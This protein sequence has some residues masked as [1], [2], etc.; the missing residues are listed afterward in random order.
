MPDPTAE[1]PTSAFT[2]A[3]VIPA[4]CLALCLALV[5]GLA[6]L[7][8]R[9]ALAEAGGAEDL[10][11]RPWAEIEARARGGEVNFFMWGGSDSINAY[12]SDYIGGLMKAR[13]DITLNRVPLTETADAVAIVLA[14]K[15]AG[16]VADGSV[17]LIWING[18]NFRTMRQGG[19]V[20]CGYTGMLPNAALVDWQ[21][22][23]VSHDFGVPVEGCEVPWSAAQMAFAHDS[24][25]VPD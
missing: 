21:S 9:P 13:Y 25:R 14:E 20:W 22:P 19:L 15:Q 5:A 6:A 10:I 17:D 7:L 2:P 4:L 23:A 24:A 18:V 11:G 12:V 3:A 16:N 8:P 1:N